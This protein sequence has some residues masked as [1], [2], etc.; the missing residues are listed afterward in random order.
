MGYVERGED[1][2][3]RR[4]IGALALLVLLCLQTG[5][6][7]SLRTIRGIPNTGIVEGRVF[8]LPEDPAGSAAVDPP[9]V[10][11]YLERLDAREGNST[12]PRIA[13]LRNT[14]GPL[15][16]EPIVVAVGQ[17]IRFSNED[18]VYHQIFSSSE[19]NAF[20]LGVF[21]TGEFRELS[22]GRE[23]V[24]RVYCSLHPWESGAIF[25]APSPRHRTVQP[26]ARYKIA[27]VPPGRYRVATWG[28]ALASTSRVVTV[29]PGRSVSME[30]PI[31]SPGTPR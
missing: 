12:A 24:V 3:D 11:V 23:G 10:V 9:H 18:E 27:G 2:A 5:C 14:E 25:V 15:W 28:E 6:E 19:I 31:E 1:P 22:L 7:S 16:P 4:R 17:T 13:T 20:D 26:P 30:L 21:K 29:Q 8:L